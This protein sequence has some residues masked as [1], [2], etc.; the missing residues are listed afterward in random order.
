M[1]VGAIDAFDTC[2]LTAFDRDDGD[3]RVDYELPR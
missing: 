3:E 1:E 2:A